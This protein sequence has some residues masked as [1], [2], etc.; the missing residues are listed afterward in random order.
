[1]SVVPDTGTSAAWFGG[2]PGMEPGD[3]VKVNNFFL[4]SSGEAEFTPLPKPITLHKV[5]VFTPTGITSYSTYVHIPGTIN[6]GVPLVKTSPAAID[7]SKPGGV[8][9]LGLQSFPINFTTKG[10][11]VALDGGP[12]HP[13][14]LDTKGFIARGRVSEPGLWGLEVTLFRTLDS[15]A[16]W[17]VPKESLNVDE[18]GARKMRNVV[19][20]MRVVGGTW[21]NF[22]FSGDLVGA[23]GAT[24]YMTFVVKGEVEASDQQVTVKNIPSPF[25]GINLTY[26]FVNHRLVG[27]LHYDRALQGGAEVK[28]SGD[29]EVLIDGDGWYF[30]AAGMMKLPSEGKEGQA[31][32][33]FGSYPMNDHIRSIFQNYSFV[34][35][36]YGTL[37][38]IFPKV[39]AGFYFEAMAAMPI[40]I[41]PSGEFDFGLIS[42]ELKH[43]VGAD[44][45]MSMQFSEGATF[46]LGQSVFAK[47]SVGLGGS[48]VIVCAGVSAELKTVLSW[49][50]QYST[51]GTWFVDGDGHIVLTGT[52][53]VGTG[54][55]DSNCESILEVGGFGTPCFKHTESGSVKLGVHGH[56]GSDYKKLE[57]YWE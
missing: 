30:L 36:E 57:F 55:C 8:M 40:P 20:N 46:G 22:T 9:K 23:N 41:I 37:P 42:G 5:A 18:A 33:I 38:A 45:R 27:S 2:L 17:V 29:A 48:V 11:D 1:L 47:I 16:I 43:Q 28:T 13:Q 19:G 34:Y 15:T 21:T 31:A 4:L 24:S 53:Y 56:Y 25:G 35:Q 6:V 50:G 49:D 54:L 32:M 14:T 10:V 44:V 51:S 12:A 39:V 52:T 7:Y 26:D 3:K